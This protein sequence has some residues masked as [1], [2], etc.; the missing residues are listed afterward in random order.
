MRIIKL[1]LVGIGVEN[2]DKE[3]LRGGSHEISEL[4][5]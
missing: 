2:Y 1:I 3:P 4:F 5:L